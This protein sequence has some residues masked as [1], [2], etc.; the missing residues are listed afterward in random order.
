MADATKTTARHIGHV[1]YTQAPAVYEKNIFHLFRFTQPVKNYSL[2]IY[3]LNWLFVC[4]KLLLGLEDKQKVIK[5]MVKLKSYTF[6]IILLL[7]V[8]VIFH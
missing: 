4:L 2:R 6:S 1:T 7:I 5:V 8:I 3:F